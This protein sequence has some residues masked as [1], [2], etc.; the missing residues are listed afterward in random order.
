MYFEEDD[1]QDSHLGSLPTAELATIDFKWL[2][3]RVS[4][5]FLMTESTDP[6]HVLTSVLKQWDLRYPVTG[7][8]Q[9]PIML[10]ESYCDPTL[11]TGSRARGLSSLALGRNHSSGLVWGI[12]ADSWSVAP[13]CVTYGRHR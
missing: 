5:K 4:H 8:A 13:P 2:V 12:A 6:P 10:Y 9:K 7:R 11:A 3:R 1:C